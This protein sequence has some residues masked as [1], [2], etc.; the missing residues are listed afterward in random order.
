M[1]RKLTRR[2][3][4]GKGNSLFEEL[5]IFSPKVQDK[6]IEKLNAEHIEKILENKDK[7]R[8]RIFRFGC[9][10]LLVGVFI[11]AALWL[12]HQNQQIFI[13]VSIGL[14]ILALVVLGAKDLLKKYLPTGS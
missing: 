9:L 8:E 2:P 4:K 14:L 7:H 3:E 13:W 5:G 11:F 10:L 6:V 1:S 12:A